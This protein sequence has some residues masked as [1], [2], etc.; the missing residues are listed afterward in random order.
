VYNSEVY[1]IIK[2]DIIKKFHILGSF[3]FLWFLV[4]MWDFISSF[5]DEKCHISKQFWKH[6][7]RWS[8]TLHFS[9]NCG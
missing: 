2:S 6:W 5:C 7:F 1:F 9:N 3:M 4:S 8:N